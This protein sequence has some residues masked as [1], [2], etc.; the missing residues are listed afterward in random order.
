MKRLLIVLGALGLAGPLALAHAPTPI[1]FYCAVEVPTDLPGPAAAGTTP[2]L[3]WTLVQ[4]NATDPYTTLIAPGLPAPPPPPPGNAQIDACHLLNDPNGTWLFSVQAP[5]DMAPS[6]PPGTTF[7]PEDVVRYDAAAGVFSHFF[8]G[9]VWGIPDGVNVDAVYLEGQR[10]DG[11]LCL[12]FDV[13]ATLGLG[14]TYKPA[15]VVRFA[16]NPPGCAGWIETGSYCFD[17]V[18]AGVPAS[19]NVT[20]ADQRGTPINGRPF[21]TF[22]VPTDLAGLAA[23]TAQPGEIVSYLGG[24]LFGLEHSDPAW[25][26]SSRMDALCLLCAPGRIPTTGNGV[27]LEIDKG[28]GA[29][30]LTLT[31]SPSCS[32]CVQDYGFYEGTIGIWNSHTAIGCT[33]TAP[34]L[35]EVINYG[36]GGRY[37][38]VVPYNANDEGSYGT[39]SNGTERPPGSPAACQ[40]TQEL[41]CP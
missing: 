21:L 34:A 12:S 3:P 4:H 13:P 38:L 39:H 7:L 32:L 10:D 8:C 14:I 5:T 17:S 25:P 2:V 35:A 36:A 29:G 6:I 40:P 28:P 26:S 20:G 18:A 31:W 23:G 24:G 15:D 16:P 19:R 11:D 22:D 37:Y 33:D 27:K 41:G 1:E 9:D 30:Q